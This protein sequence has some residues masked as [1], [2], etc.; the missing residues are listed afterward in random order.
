MSMEWL[1]SLQGSGSIHSPNSMYRKPKAKSPGPQ[2]F[3]APAGLDTKVRSA[4]PRPSNYSAPQVQSFAT[5]TPGG[6]GGG[7][8]GSTTQSQSTSQNYSQ[9]VYDPYAAAQAAAAAEAARIKAEEDTKRKKLR[10][11][12]ESYLDKLLAE[13]EAILK[14]IEKVGKDQTERLNKEYD[15]K[16]EGQIEDMNYG[17]YDVD[18]SAAASNLADSSFRSFDRGKVRKAADENIATLNN[19][20]AGDL[21]EVGSMVSRETGRFNAEKRGIDRTRRLLGE[22]ED[23]GELTSTVNSLDK[24]YRGMGAEKAK[25]G[26]RGEFVGKANKLGNY[27]TSQLEAALKSVVGNSSA[28][29]AAKMATAGDILKGSG[30]PEE[31]RKKLE[32]KYIQIV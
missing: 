22:T 13:Y 20:R 27:D 25:F 1:K 17:M 30:A 23:V 10:G 31:V 2:P 16:I 21:A 3:K 6:G 9:P 19:A 24:T 29:P 26:T 12:G 15:G 7:G 5:T 28:T 32:K 18:A 11:E 4:T 14:M 8:V